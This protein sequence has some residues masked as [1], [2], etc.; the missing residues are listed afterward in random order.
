[1]A[2]I[3]VYMLLPI[4]IYMLLAI[5]KRWHMQSPKVNGRIKNRTFKVNLKILVRV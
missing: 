4:L 3:L 2:H 1:M 5:I